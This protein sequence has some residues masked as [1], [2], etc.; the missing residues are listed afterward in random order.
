MNQIRAR[1]PA[2]P[3]M[4]DVASAHDPISTATV[5]AHDPLQQRPGRRDLAFRWNLYRDTLTFKRDEKSG[6]GPTPFLPWRRVGS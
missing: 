4:A 3:E 5:A 2:A 1:G 6:V